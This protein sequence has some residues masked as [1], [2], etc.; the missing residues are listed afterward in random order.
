MLAPMTT[1]STADFRLIGHRGAAG[2]AIENSQAAF[3]KA[4]ALGAA[5]VE[6]DV[7]S[8]RDGARVVFH[9][10]HLGR[11]TGRRGNLARQT[12]ASLVDYP[13]SDGSLIPDLEPILSTLAQ[14]GVGVYVEIKDHRPVMAGPILEDIQRSGANCVVSSFH[15]AVLDE[16][17]RCGWRGP[18]M[19]LFSRASAAMMAATD[20]H[21]QIG[22][23]L[24]GAA[25]ARTLSLVRAGVPVMAYTVNDPAQICWLKA[26]GLSGVFTDYPAAQLPNLSNN[27]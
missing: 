14:A 20:Q 15:G 18:T 27:A 7:Q 23:G 6:L 9:D 16:I 13:L 3:D 4:V 25:H 11:M 22:V 10:T 8:L 2:L 21:A 26:R 5:W 12:R 1:P 17:K 19:A 24:A